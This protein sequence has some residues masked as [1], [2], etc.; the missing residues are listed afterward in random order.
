MNDKLTHVMSTRYV[1]RTATI[2]GFSDETVFV[3]GEGGCT[4]I[5]AT[6]VC[7]LSG[8]C[9]YVQLDNERIDINKYS[10]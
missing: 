6:G 9:S 5:D 7:P 3:T 10:H 2:T 4:N 1:C 8:Q